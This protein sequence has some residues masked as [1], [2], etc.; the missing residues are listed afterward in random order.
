MR[1]ISWSQVMFLIYKKNL[2]CTNYMH[3][4]TKIEFMQDTIYIIANRVWD[5]LR[6]FPENVS[7]CSQREIQR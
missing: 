7:I 2:I 1:S 5:R 4:I 3:D 6:A